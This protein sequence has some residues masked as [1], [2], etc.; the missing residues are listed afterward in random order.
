[1]RRRPTQRRSAARVERML[2]ACAELLEEV[3]YEELSTTRIARRAD[4]AI[5]SVYQFFP[6]KRAIAQALSLRYLAVFSE[7]ISARLAGGGYR[8]WFDTVD[9][10]IDEYV[11][12]HRGEPGF[13]ELRFGDVVDPRLLDSAAE[14]NT[15]LAGHLALLLTTHLGA[16]EGPEVARALSVAVEAADAVLKMAFRRS[17]EGDPEIIAEAKRLVHGYLAASFRG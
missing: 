7:R 11:A 9:T 2:D 4:V 1:M 13:R 12:M 14:N 6:D 16:P 10:V 5:G 15:V 3:G 17:P 8:D